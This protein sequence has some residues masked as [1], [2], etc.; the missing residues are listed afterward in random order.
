MMH[1]QELL[2][3]YASWQLR[4]AFCRVASHTDVLRG[5]SRILYAGCLRLN[6]ARRKNSFCGYKFNHKN[7]FAVGFTNRSTTTSFS[8]V[9]SINP[10]TYQLKQCREVGGGE[11]GGSQSPASHT[12]F[13]RLPYVFVSL[14]PDSRPLLCFSR[15]HVNCA[16]W[17][18]IQ[19]LIGS[20]LAL[21]K[22]KNCVVNRTT[23]HFPARSLKWHSFDPSLHHAAKS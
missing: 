12:P 5:S 22:I 6:P 2:L 17:L 18:P 4:V 15:Y 20:A 1:V 13:S 3:A 19:I 7:I 21:S 10:Y 8:D 14:F 23:P 16:V 9:K 11:T